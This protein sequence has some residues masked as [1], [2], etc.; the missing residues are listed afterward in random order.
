LRRRST[1][2]S[3]ESIDFMSTLP[4]PTYQGCD[5]RKGDAP[6][7]SRARNADNDKVETGLSLGDKTVID[8]G[9]QEEESTD[10]QV[11]L[12]VGKAMRAMGAESSVDGVKHDNEN[13]D[14]TTIAG[15]GRR[16]ASESTARRA[17]PPYNPS[18]M[19]RFRSP[20]ALAEAAEGWRGR[21]QGR[22]TSVAQAAD[23][24]GEL[25]VEQQLRKGTPGCASAPTQMM[26]SPEMSPEMYGET[27]PT[28][29]GDHPGLH[30]I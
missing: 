12:D 15:S 5:G 20:R 19:M 6:A 4:R 1:A 7:A 25:M 9:G 3:L 13:A 11:G 16:V 29:P 23:N 28:M 26:L 24:Y 21:A 30:S 17:P 2:L 8:A 18:G 10:P 14:E 22:S 27:A